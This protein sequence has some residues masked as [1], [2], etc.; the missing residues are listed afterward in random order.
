VLAPF[1]LASGRLGDDVIMTNV[2]SF[3]VQVYDPG[4]PLFVSNGTLVEPRDAGYRQQL[5]AVA[6]S[7]PQPP[8]VAGWGAYVDLG[9]GKIQTND[10]GPQYT[11]SITPVTYAPTPATAP[12]YLVPLFAGPPPTLSQFPSSHGSGPFGYDTWSWH[13]ENDGI[14]QN[15][16]AT[17]ADAGTNGLDDVDPSTG[18]VNGIVDD[19]TERDTLPPY[20]VPLRG[21]RV[22]I[23]VYEP[24]SQQVRQVTVVQDY[25][26]D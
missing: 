5:A 22:T 24:S 14:Q 1:N 17:I 11:G 19:I 26:P 9:Y 10:L 13:Y 21:I 4:A 2:L 25:L 15:S 18:A 6:G 20:N 7:Y 12:S 23:R 3:D 8:P 16:F